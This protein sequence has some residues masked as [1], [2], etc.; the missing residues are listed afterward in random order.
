ML[1][2]LARDKQA[3]SISLRYLN[4]CFHN[5]DREVRNNYLEVKV[6]IGWCLPANIFDRE[7]YGGENQYRQKYM[8]TY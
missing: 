4:I 5:F 1:V 3:D 7:N 2:Y 6:Y 8:H